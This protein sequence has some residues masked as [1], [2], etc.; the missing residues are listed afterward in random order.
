MQSDSTLGT[1][2]HIS[3]RKLD[4][5]D[6][7]GYGTHYLF[8]IKED[9][10]YKRYDETKDL[11]GLYTFESKNMMSKAIKNGYV[12]TYLFDRERGV[13]IGNDKKLSIVI[14]GRNKNI[15]FRTELTEDDT[16]VVH[17]MAENSYFSR[18]AILKKVYSFFGIDG[19]SIILG[20][21][22]K[23]VLLRAQAMELNFMA[24]ANVV[25]IQGLKILLE[26]ESIISDADRLA[27]F[28]ETG[29]YMGEEYVVE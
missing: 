4:G 27:M 6:S 20:R 5:I 28:P 25:N 29:Q 19:T 18:L 1:L 2:D 10:F 17:T 8:P 14:I 16:G 13:I 12:G 23:K 22:S 9:F 3:I 11:M 15:I 21:R 24:F 7:K 26:L